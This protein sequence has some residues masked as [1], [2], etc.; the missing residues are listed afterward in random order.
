MFG[1]QHDRYARHVAQCS[2]GGSDLGQQMVEG[3]LVIGACTAVVVTP[4]RNVVLGP[5]DGERGE[6]A[7]QGYGVIGTTTSPRRG[8][9]RLQRRQR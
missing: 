9:R 3:R 8:L 4:K 5:K 1:Q 2:V 7:A 6:W